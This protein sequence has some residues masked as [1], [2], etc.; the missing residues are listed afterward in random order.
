MAILQL[1]IPM[2][3]LPIEFEQDGNDARYVVNLPGAA[4]PAELAF[5]RIAPQVIV[6]DHTFVPPEGRGMGIALALVERLISYARENGD[7]IVPTC[8]YVAKEFK[9]HPEWSDLLA[10]G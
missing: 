10:E 5:V 8:P 4:Q 1:E 3:T 9:A 6:A 2:I 7:K